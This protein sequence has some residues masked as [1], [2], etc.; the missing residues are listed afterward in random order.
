MSYPQ[1]F[2]QNGFIIRSTSD[3]PANGLFSLTKWFK[4][5]LTRYGV[6]FK[7]ECC[8]E[9]PANQPVRFN[10]TSGHLEYYHTTTNTWVTVPNL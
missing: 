8:V 2:I 4:K 1:Y 7:D 5:M 10:S 6:A 9:D 3:S